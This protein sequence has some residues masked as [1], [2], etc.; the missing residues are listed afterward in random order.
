MQLLSADPA[1]STLSMSV[2]HAP[3]SPAGGPDVKVD[4]S[5][6]EQAQ[7]ESAEVSFVF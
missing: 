3:S 4:L 6:D 7:E 1:A 2:S 5:E